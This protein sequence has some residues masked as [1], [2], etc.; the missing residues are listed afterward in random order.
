MGISENEDAAVVAWASPLPEDLDRPLEEVRPG[1]TTTGFD[2]STLVDGRTIVNEIDD[3]TIEPGESL[4]IGVLVD[5]RESTIEDNPIPAELTDAITL[6][7]E[8]TDS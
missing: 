3:R 8:S 7:A 6:F 5:T 1:L 2:G 4:N